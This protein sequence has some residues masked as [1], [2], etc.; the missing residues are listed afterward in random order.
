LKIIDICSCIEEFAPLS[1]QESWDNCGLLVG[2]PQ[3]TVHK[4]LLTV[5]VT[6]AVIAEAVDVQAQMIVSHHPFIL[7][8]IK[9]LTGSTDAQR[10]I[11]MAVKNDIAIYAAHTNMDAAPGGVSY[12][13]AA[14][15]GLSQLQALSPQG[16]G[17]QKLVTYIP[18]S[19]F[20]QVRRAVFEAGAGH[21]GNYDSCGYSAEGKGTFRALDGAHP[22]VGQ[23]GML[24]TEPE[25]RFET[26]FPSRLNRQIVSA[27]LS[28][29]P[30]EEPA[31][32]IYALQNTDTRVGLGVVG[33]LPD[34]V[35]ELHFL[36]TLKETFL[37]PVIR[38]T[39]LK[40]KK[41][42]RVALCGGSGSSLLANA[43]GSKA[44]VFVTADFKYH[45]FADAEQDI[46][47]ADIGH[48]ESEQFIKD[49]FYEV[50]VKK[51]PTF[52]VH[53]SKIKTNPINYL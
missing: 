15:L 1:W 33:M 17:L 44:D 53:F 22:F 31:L 45:Q 12:R 8:G 42:Q 39:H 48:F 2:N 40:N 18:S 47:V 24:H 6:E 25:I 13:M 30:Y 10:V 36:N 11:A 41:I 29:H 27:L 21:I 51:I 23:H 35:D 50:L 49:I 19:H 37:A 20:E 14:K 3:Q 32:D 43:I 4:V 34:P 7:S 28:S 26:V 16:A 38:H 9:Q 52:A 46:L 5:D